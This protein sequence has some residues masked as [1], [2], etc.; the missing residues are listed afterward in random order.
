MEPL[1]YLLGKARHSRFQSVNK[2]TAVRSCSWLDVLK[3]SLVKQKLGAII[4]QV[5]PN[6]AKTLAV[7]EKWVLAQPTL[8]LQEKAP[9]IPPAFYLFIYLLG[10]ISTPQ[11]SK[12]LIKIK[13]DEYNFFFPNQGERN[14]R[15]RKRKIESGIALHSKCR[16][17]VLCTGWKW[18]H[19]WL[20]ASWQ[21]R[22]QGKWPPENK[23]W[24]AWVRCTLSWRWML[25]AVCPDGN[26]V[27][28]PQ[29]HLTI[30]H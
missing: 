21:P 13:R 11:R 26:T 1:G 27:L 24:Y 15:S 16:T 7:K 12:S 30:M 14:I 23:K 25:T 8:S 2:D 18:A 28:G 20:W 9:E 22:Q 10:P 19:L 4:E 29:P 5:A 6:R 3:G 17:K